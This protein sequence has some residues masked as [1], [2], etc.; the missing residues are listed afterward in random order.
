MYGTHLRIS[1]SCSNWSV[2]TPKCFGY[3]SREVSDTDHYQVSD[4]LR[5]Q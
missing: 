1:T 4:S 3:A 5:S 2:G